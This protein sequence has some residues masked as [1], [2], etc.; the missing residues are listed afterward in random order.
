MDEHGSRMA[1]LERDEENGTLGSGSSW[2][3]RLA[4][5]LTSQ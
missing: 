2:A 4:A 5:S 1:A 3:T